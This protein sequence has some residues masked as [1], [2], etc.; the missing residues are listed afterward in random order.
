MATD[1]PYGQA[2]DQ[3]QYLGFYV[4]SEEY[5]VGILKIK[6]IIEYDVVTRVPGTPHYVRG[7][8]NLRGSV[9]PVVDLSAKLGL[10]DSEVTKRTCIVILETE[11]E[12]TRRT[13]GAMVDAVSQVIELGPGDVEPP[14]AFGSKVNVQYIVGMGRAG[15]RFVLLLDIDRAISFLESAETAPPGSSARASAAADE[16]ARVDAS[17]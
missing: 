9:V 11:L 8:I 7:V 6:E 15:K 17:A 3:S 5:G 14:P 16:T 1:M 13:V 12:G 4:G 10:G 2:Y